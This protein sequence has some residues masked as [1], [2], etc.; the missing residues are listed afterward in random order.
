M[1]EERARQ[2]ELEQ[3]M[4]ARRRSEIESFRKDLARRSDAMARQAADGIHQAVQKLEAS[5]KPSPAVAGRARSEAVQAVRAA[6]AEAMAGLQAP[7][8]EAPEAELAVGAR[9]RVRS[10]GVVGEVIA[11]PGPGE[12]ELA[13]GG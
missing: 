6:Q 1:D 7:V 8:E 13:V 11:L 12:V 9:A 3:V 5:R 4:A 2:K 10:L